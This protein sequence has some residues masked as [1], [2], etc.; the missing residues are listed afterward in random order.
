MSKLKVKSSKFKV[1]ILILVALILGYAIYNQQKAKTSPAPST[2]ESSQSQ[3]IPS[4]LTE[5]EKFILNPPSED[6]SQSAKDKHRDTV[7]KLAKEGSKLEI[8]DCKPDILVLQ[9][10]QGS[11]ITIQNKDSVPHKIIFD[12][13]HY[14]GV[15]ANGKTTIKAEFKYGTGD[16]GYVC[17][18]VGLTG[19]LHIAP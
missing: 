15:E 8:K 5:D 7:A 13:E 11:P 16:Y 9:A 19:F 17:E 1:I 14:Y 18:G 4:T 12:S 3:I 2:R 10:K 6:A